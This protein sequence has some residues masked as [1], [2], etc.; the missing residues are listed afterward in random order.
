MIF[1][2]WQKDPIH[3]ITWLI[4]KDFRSRSFNLTNFPHLQRF[5][6]GSQDSSST[7]L[8]PAS[9]SSNVY[10]PHQTQASL[11]TKQASGQATKRQ[12][13]SSR[14]NNS[15]REPLSGTSHFGSQPLIS[16]KASD[17]VELSSVEQRHTLTSK[18]KLFHPK[19]R[20]KRETRS[21]PSC[22][23]RS[24]NTS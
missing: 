7:P 13:T 10:N 19:R 16:T 1:S 24:C 23:T 3:R 21:A 15:D 2:L 14:S 22:P 5:H 11:L 17:T 12:T 9:S 6:V 18:S 8:T 20:T 4:N